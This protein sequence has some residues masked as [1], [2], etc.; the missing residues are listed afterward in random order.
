LFEAAAVQFE[1]GDYASALRLFEESYQLSQRTLLLYNMGLSAERLG[2][3]D[4]AIAAYEAYL[5]AADATPARQEVTDRLK[6]L[7]TTR[8]AIV[9]PD[10]TSPGP[11]IVSSPGAS[12]LS[13]VSSS[14]ARRT[15][16]R[17]W[18][19]GAA[20]VV[21]GGAAIAAMALTFSGREKQHSEPRTTVG[22]RVEALVSW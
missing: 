11:A 4:R 14:D 15:T 1:R 7:R 5:S 17:R 16:R 22:D 21:L 19:L 6:R 8:K 13:D 18:L 3:N 12:P 2:Q 9:A 20:G 10:A